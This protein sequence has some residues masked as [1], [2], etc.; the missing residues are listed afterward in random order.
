MAVSADDVGEAAE[1]IAGD[2]VRTPAAESRTLSALTGLDVVVKF[3]NLQF[4]ASFKDR[5]AANKLRQLTDAERNIGVLAVS[6]GNHAQS[7]AYHA[8]RLG[9]AATIVM[10]ASAP[11]TKVANT[12]AL[13]AEVV[14][15]G[16]TF[17]DAVAVAE[18]LVR[19]RGL[20]MVHPYDDPAVIAGQGTVA[21]E[22]LDDV[23]GIGTLLVPVG[24]GGL[25]AGV[26]AYTR[27]VRPDIELIGVQ[28]EVYPGMIA[29]LAGRELEPP[30]AETLADGIA[31]KSPGRLTVPMVRDL[32]DEVL[33]VPEA[34]IERA[35]SLYL[36][37]EKTVVEGAGAV[38]LAAV[39]ED[40]E[41][42]RGKRVGLILSGGNIDT[43]VL[44]S[45]LM[46][47]LVHSGRITTVRISLP[48]LPGSLA[49]VLSMVA[50]SGANVIEIDH[51]RLFDPISARATNVDVVIE[52]RD[53]LH[54]ATVLAAL[55]QAGYQAEILAS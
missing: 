47:E 27:A 26:A 43:R 30:R 29:A 41:R 17:A 13:G 16:A 44:A 4:T 53:R 14:Q 28:S 49:P 9:I 6:A 5:G 32:V 3:E 46:R 33:A 15:A 7:V 42:W 54:T 55:Q 18:R 2:V 20:T 31:V 19:E 8:T 37:I 36:E 50:V 40:P 39:L 24:G 34:A 12:E 25:L 10:P 45:V 35:V 11:F 1:R 23:D 51:R 52:T 22:L 48:D 21:V 38:G